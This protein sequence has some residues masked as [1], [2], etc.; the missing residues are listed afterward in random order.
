[1]LDSCFYDKIKILQTLSSLAWYIEKHAEPN[2]KCEGNLKCHK[3]WVKLK[4]ELEKHC[5]TI[6]D[7]LEK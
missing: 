1:M 5:E 4:K 2:A 6:K 7:S 3:Y